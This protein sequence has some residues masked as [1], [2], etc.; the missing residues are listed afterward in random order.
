VIYISRHGLRLDK[1]IKG[2]RGDPNPPIHNSGI[3]PLLDESKKIH[4]IDY[5]FCSPF[6]RCVQT[7]H[8]LN[9][10]DAPI[11]IEYGMS[12]TL[13]E[14]WFKKCGYNPLSRLH[15]SHELSLHYYNVDTT[16][17]SYM[18]QEFPESRRDSRKRAKSFINWLKKS[19]YLEK[20]IL[21]VGH[22]FSVKDCLAN[23]GMVPPFQ[24]WEGGFPDMGKV[25]VVK[26]SDVC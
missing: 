24:G 10:F 21:L 11:F 26:E 8:Y 12:E 16:Y 7:A 4:N 25:F 6:L 19:E 17:V 23:L 3:R 20:D 9:R 14:K 13:R 22:A 2:Y 1:V 15:N 5:V 18:K